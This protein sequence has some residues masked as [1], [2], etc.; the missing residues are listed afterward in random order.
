MQWSTITRVARVWSVRAAIT[1]FVLSASPLLARSAAAAPAFTP[2]PG[3]PFATSGSPEAVAFSPTGHLVATADGMSGL[4]SVFSVTPGGSLSPAAGSPL[5]LGTNTIDV[6]FNPSGSLLAASEP[7]ADAVSVFS[8]GAAGQLTPVPG[9][10][11][12]A[13]SS[14]QGV[15]FSPSGGLLA[16]GNYTGDSISMFAVEP[17]GT[18]AQSRGRRS[19]PAPARTPWP[20]ARTADC[21]PPRTRAAPTRC[22]C[23]RSAWAAV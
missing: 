3:S 10:P 21:S 20:S 19:R 13:G 9:S 23:S 8:V 6:A 1:V 11:F 12:A 22:R 7:G 16:V 2:V 5:S 17:N 4:V 14:P 15:A 18:L